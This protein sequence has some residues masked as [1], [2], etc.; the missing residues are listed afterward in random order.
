LKAASSWQPA[1]A[2]ALRISS[3][4]SADAAAIDGC[5]PPLLALAFALFFDDAR[6]LVLGYDPAQ[7]PFSFRDRE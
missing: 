4:S 5:P 3:S 1:A 6:P 2:I 7:R